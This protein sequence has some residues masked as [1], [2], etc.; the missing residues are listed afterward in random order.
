[1]PGE[2]E[3]EAEGWQHEWQEQKQRSWSG[4][5]RDDPRDRERQL[6]SVVGAG[7]GTSRRIL[8][9]FFLIELTRFANG[10]DVG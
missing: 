7:A 9:V 3:T 1:M 5:Y 2:E 4:S 8:G 10:L 6:K